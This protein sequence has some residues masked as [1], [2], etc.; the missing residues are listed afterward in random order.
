[1]KNFSKLNFRLHFKQNGLMKIK[2]A[3]V[4]F[5]VRC[6]YFITIKLE[7]WVNCFS[8]LKLKIFN[9]NSVIHNNP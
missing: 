5:P 1:M 2:K 8:S 9:L 3:K 7:I 6:L 4:S